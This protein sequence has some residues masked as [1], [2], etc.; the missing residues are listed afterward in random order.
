M[1]SH[2]ALQ[3]AQ[4]DK[5]PPEPIR[6]RRVVT[7]LAVKIRR[8][9]EL[10]AFFSKC[11]RWT[12]DRRARPA[13]IS[14]AAVV[15]AS[16]IAAAFHDLDQQSRHMVAHIAAMN[17]AA[18]VAAALFA[19]RIARRLGPQ[20]LWALVVAQ[21]GLL[22]ASHTP[23]AHAWLSHSHAAGLAALVVLFVLAVLFWASALGQYGPRLWHSVG[24]LLITGKLTCLLAALLVFST[25]PLYL[26]S[27]AAGDALSDQ[28]LAG[29]LMLAA[30]PVSYV[31]AAIV[32]TAD[33]IGRPS[34][35]A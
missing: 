33:L 24:A 27:N 14:A 25:R 7:G 9:A 10:D 28:Q 26:N 4:G 34:E 12:F 22:W 35:R 31:V 15:V 13:W 1:Q 17:V 5:L 30:C 18:P 21:V 29:L 2:F 11:S 32:I 3:L 20:M 23:Q 8:G 19:E 6:V 16:S